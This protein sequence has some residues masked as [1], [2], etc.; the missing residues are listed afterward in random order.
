MQSN[1][2]YKSFKT[3]SKFLIIKLYSVISVPLSIIWKA[4]LR[5]WKIKEDLIKSDEE[6]IIINENA[7]ETGTLSTLK[8]D[9]KKKER[10][11]N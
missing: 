5:K 2:R 8:I 9:K 6:I 1:F 7:I 3:F 10:N 4:V 11:K